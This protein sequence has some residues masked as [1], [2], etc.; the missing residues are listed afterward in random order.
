VAG[1]DGAP[2]ALQQMG[3]G[4]VQCDVA[5]HLYKIGHDGIA[6]AIKAARGEAVAERIDTGH[7]VV[8]P[9]N[10]KQFIVDNHL[11]KFMQ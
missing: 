11:E 5:Q 8:T 6:T 2:D 10:V 1:F 4:W 9:D 3:S 7:A